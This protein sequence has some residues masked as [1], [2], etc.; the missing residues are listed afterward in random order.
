M[1][2]KE[3]RKII[4]NEFPDLKKENRSQYNT[5][6]SLLIKYGAYESRPVEKLVSGK[7]AEEIINCIPTN[8]LDP[9]LTG[10]DK[11]LPD[12]YNYNPKDIEKLLSALKERVKDKVSKFSR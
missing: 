10:K 9:L 7:F 2:E 11:I 3:A 5:L 1:K 4:S 8:W 12:G 6:V